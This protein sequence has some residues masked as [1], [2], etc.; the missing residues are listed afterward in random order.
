PTLDIKP[1][2][3]KIDAPDKI[4]VDIKA[5]RLD[6]VAIKLIPPNLATVDKVALGKDG[7]TINLQGL[8]DGKVTI[9]AR[10]FKN[11]GDVLIVSGQVQV[12]GP[13]VKM[14]DAGYNGPIMI[15][16]ADQT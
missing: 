3:P 2:K 6:R 13:L 11:E 10:G 1:E 7:G 15:A 5:T 8:M 14:N 9:E 12:V 16:M 4:K